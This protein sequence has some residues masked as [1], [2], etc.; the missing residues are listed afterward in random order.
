MS[1]TRSLYLLSSGNEHTI[2][3]IVIVV[4]QFTQIVLKPIVNKSTKI[5]TNNELF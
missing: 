2:E 1:E 5:I 3:P 4:I